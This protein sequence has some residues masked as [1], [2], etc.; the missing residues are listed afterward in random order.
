MGTQGCEEERKVAVDPALLPKS[1]CS[2]ER[3]KYSQTSSDINKGH[4]SSVLPIPKT[5]GF[6]F[7]LDLGTDSRQ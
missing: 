2:S 7:L 3:G 4:K 6:L 1:S 5:E